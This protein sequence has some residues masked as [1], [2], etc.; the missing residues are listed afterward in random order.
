[1]EERAAKEPGQTVVLKSGGMAFTVKVRNGEAILPKRF[2]P[3]PARR[4]I[5]RKAATKTAIVRLAGFN[6][7]SDYGPQAV[8]ERLVNALGNNAVAALLGVNKDRPGRWIKGEDTPNEENR[9]QLTDL[10]SLMG[11]L[12]TAFT[13]EQGRLWLEGHNAQLGA[14]PIDVYRL[15]GSAPVIEAMQAHGQGTFA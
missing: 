13:A 7:S 8:T 5:R 2:Q 6:A 9:L 4:P 15:E 11:H 12:L 1:M 3:V 10:N 14:R